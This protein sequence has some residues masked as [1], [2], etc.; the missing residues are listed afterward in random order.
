VPTQQTLRR[1][2]PRK[3][4]WVALGISLIVAGV[5]LGILPVV[6]GTPLTLL[7]LALASAHSPR[8]RLVRQRAQVWLLA[9]GIRLRLARRRKAALPLAVRA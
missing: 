1:S 6:P 4:L 5:L 2:R 7:G 8:M 9:K 3:R